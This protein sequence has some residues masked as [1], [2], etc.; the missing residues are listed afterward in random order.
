L[1]STLE[2]LQ[3]FYIKLVNHSKTFKNWV[4]DLHKYCLHCTRCHRAITIP[5]YIHGI[6][7][8]AP[9]AMLWHMGMVSGI[10]NYHHCPFILPNREAMFYSCA[11]FEDL[12]DKIDKKQP[13]PFLQCNASANQGM[14]RFCE[15]TKVDLQ[16]SKISNTNQN[17]THNNTITNTISLVS[18]M[19]VDMI[20]VDMAIDSGFLTTRA[21]IKESSITVENCII[22][23]GGTSKEQRFLVEPEGYNPSIMSHYQMEQ[24]RLYKS[25]CAFGHNEYTKNLICVLEEI[26][27]RMYGPSATIPNRI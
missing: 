26:A 23:N 24:L 21:E 14:I 15:A 10:N 1:K 19:F 25:W 8:M 27:R 7:D 12:R 20:D 9:I 11:Q 18:S 13:S 3:Q 17:K 4:G 16:S 2:L 22:W 5:D 6:M